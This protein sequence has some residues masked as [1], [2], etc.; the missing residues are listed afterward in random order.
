MF[1]GFLRTE[2]LGC[3]EGE[4]PVFCTRD[5]VIEFVE[6]SWPHLAYTIDVSLDVQNR[7]K[8]LCGQ[9]IDVSLLS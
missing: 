4:A 1:I 9:I 2:A 7:R 6:R 5:S 8:S 3:H